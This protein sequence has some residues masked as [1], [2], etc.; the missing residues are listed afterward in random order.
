M[1][2][3]DWLMQNVVIE[4]GAFEI[5]WVTRGGKSTTSA[6]E[7]TNRRISDKIVTV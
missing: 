6:N 1:S 3:S 4:M 2:S 7:S 5:G